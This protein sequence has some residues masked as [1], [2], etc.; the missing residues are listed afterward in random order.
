[1]RSLE[2]NKYNTDTYLQ[3]INKVDTLNSDNSEY[4]QLVNKNA[5]L[6]GKVYNHNTIK[7][8]SSC[9]VKDE[10]ITLIPPV[11][12]DD[13]TNGEDNSV[14]EN[15]CTLSQISKMPT[16]LM[17]EKRI[18]CDVC[19]QTV[20]DKSK[21]IIH[22]RKHTGEKPFSCEICLK[23]FS[24]SHHAKIHMRTHSGYKPFQCSYCDKRFKRS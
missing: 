16:K 6:E 13:T 18:Q 15:K 12:T 24:T 20:K 7:S 3:N 11:T 8:S 19:L 14:E 9:Y 2:L 22:M 21:L 4:C 10:D 17:K 5:E 23:N 1:M